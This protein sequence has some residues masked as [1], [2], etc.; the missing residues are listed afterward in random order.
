MAGVGVLLRHVTSLLR[1]EFD[2]CGMGSIWRMSHERRDGTILY[3]KLKRKTAL[4]KL[5]EEYCR[6]QSLRLDE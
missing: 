5:F 6:R 1:A 3:F 4:R 2:S